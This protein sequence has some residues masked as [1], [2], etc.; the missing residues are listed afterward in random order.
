[1]YT[2]TGN[3]EQ[4]AMT[5]YRPCSTMADYD[6]A[7]ITADCILPPI[8]HYFDTHKQRK[9]SD[10]TLSPISDYVD[11]EYVPDNTQL[12]ITDYN[13]AIWAVVVRRVLFC[14]IGCLLSEAG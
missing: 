3:N 6:A 5:Q 10:D 4:R 13:V 1:C 11:V 2:A 9:A 14:I 12:P 7:P 8:F